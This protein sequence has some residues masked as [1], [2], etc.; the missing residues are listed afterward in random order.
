MLQRTAGRGDGHIDVAC[1]R[2]SIFASVEGVGLFC[3][4]WSDVSSE[5]NRLR[6]N[7]I[8]RKWQRIRKRYVEVCARR[9]LFALAGTQ[10]L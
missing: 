1:H 8:A 2:L 10:M 9:P 4:P 6:D 5:L 7:S 3:D